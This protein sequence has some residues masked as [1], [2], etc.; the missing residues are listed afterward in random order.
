MYDADAQEDKDE[1]AGG[2]G[3]HAAGQPH[4]QRPQ[5]A[6]DAHDGTD[7]IQGQNGSPLPESHSHDAVVQVAFVRLHDGFVVRHAPYDGE[8]GIEDRQRQDEDG[9]D[10]REQRGAL[11]WLIAY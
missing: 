1:H 6:C 11:R 3:E 5:D 9:D 4:V 7:G 8:G 10:R 2:G